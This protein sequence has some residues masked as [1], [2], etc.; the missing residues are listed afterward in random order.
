V[1]AVENRGERLI[2]L[3]DL[4]RE[5]LAAALSLLPELVTGSLRKLRVRTWNGRPVRGSEVEG[6]L[7]EL[8]FTRDPNALVLYR[9][10]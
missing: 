3:A 6:F 7:V 8:G 4:P 2:G 9:R 5:E 1:L 10:Y